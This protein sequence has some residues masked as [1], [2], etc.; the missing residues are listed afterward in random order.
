MLRQL[1]RSL[2]LVA[3]V[4]V[5]GIL[6]AGVDIETLFGPYM[7]RGTE[8][9]ESTDA[10]FPTV[11]SPRWSEWKPPTWTGAIKP[12]TEHDLREIVRIAASHNISFMA[13]NGGHGTGV[14]YG[15]VKSI[16]VN[17]ANF[18]SVKID[19]ATN[20]LIVGAGTKVGDITEPLYKAGKTVPH[21]NSASVGMIGATIGGGIGFETGLFGLGIDALESVRLVTATGDVVTASDKCNPELFWAIRGAGANFGII[22]EATF[23]MTDQPNNGN[24]VIGS[25]VYPASHALAV[26][27]L[28]Q[29]LDNILPAELAFQLAIS[30]NRTTNASEVTVDLTHF[31]S[32]DT[33][34]PHLDVAEKLGPIAR[35]V[36]NVTL[37]ELY[38]GS[39]GPPQS[40]VY[41]SSGTIGLGRTDPQT[42]QDVL[43]EMTAFYEAYPE[44]HGQTIFQH[45]ASNNTLKTPSDTTVYPWRDTKTFWRHENIYTDPA[46]EVPSIQ[47]FLSLRGK[48]HATSG[49]SEPHIYVN[50]AYGDEGPEGWWSAANLP[51]LRKL[52]H[53]WDPKRLFGLGTPVF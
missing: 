23:R 31:G 32:W 38:A 18:N 3:V 49:F 24:A 42:M 51:K 14:I 8:I 39:D 27:N 48:L 4:H 20:R 36:K 15:T 2:A 33:F 29:A 5:I 44:Y 45:Y 50:Y 30:Y 22:T 34:V 6:A 16:D 25:F 17:L 41:I 21:A 19:V 9:A 11:V 13:T 1:C 40:G 35:T 7:S 26:F 37:V 46:L 47:L 53:K 10:N 43:D 28:M 12:Q 52:K